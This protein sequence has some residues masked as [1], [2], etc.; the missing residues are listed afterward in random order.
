MDANI[1]NR[2]TRHTDATRAAYGLGALPSRLARRPATASAGAMLGPLVNPTGGG[3]IT[4]PPAYDLSRAITPFSVN[5]TGGGFIPRTAVA[6]AVRRVVTPFGIQTFVDYSA[7]SYAVGVRGGST[8]GGGGNIASFRT[9][10]I[11]VSQ[12]SSYDAW[13]ESRRFAEALNDS[14]QNNA[15][16]LGNLGDAGPAPSYAGLSEDNPFRFPYRISPP[17]LTSA[18]RWFYGRD[19]WNVG[20]PASWY[21]PVEYLRFA[22]VANDW[23]AVEKWIRWRRAAQGGDVGWNNI[24][25]PMPA[26]AVQAPTMLRPAVGTRDRGMVSLAGLAGLGFALPAGLSPQIQQMIAQNIANAAPVDPLANHPGLQDSGPLPPPA[27]GLDNHGV[28]YDHL[29]SRMRYVI[30]N[31]KPFYMPWSLNNYMTFAARFQRAQGGKWAGARGSLLA[32]T[33]NRPTDGCLND[34]EAQFR[35]EFKDALSSFDGSRPWLVNFEGAGCD[36]GQ[37]FFKSTLGKIV[38]GVAAIAATWGAVS[39]ISGAASAAGGASAGAVG[40]GGAGAAGATGAAVGTASGVAAGSTAAGV[41][42]AGAAAAAT[43]PEIIVVASSLAPA[44]SPGLVAAGVAASG[45]AALGITSGGSAAASAPNIPPMSEPLTAP[46]ETLE[47][48]TVTATPLPT[49]PPAAVVGGAAAVTAAVG[50]TAGG[51]GAAADIPTLDVTTGPE[52]LEPVTVTASPLPPPSPVVPA[53]I[54]AGAV[55]AGVI[56][57]GG[58]AAAPTLPEITVTEPVLDTQLP[59]LPSEPG[60]GAGAGGGAGAGSGGGLLDTI[61]DAIS[62]AGQIIGGGGVPVLP[63]LPSLDFPTLPG[64]GAGAGGGAGG[65]AA[66]GGAKSLLPFALAGLAL[67]LLANDKNRKRT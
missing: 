58:G 63:S 66:A 59:E 15:A 29:W 3:L 38:L 14:T 7:P 9:S 28:G 54:G 37:A 49:V 13:E 62:N 52:T 11:L 47:S 27:E 67:L 5:P 12:Q 24:L 20:A 41:A 39:L 53:V 46:V 21:D 57:A 45:A 42:T 2:C 40:A 43:L 36:A 26:A 1:L 18:Y 34:R 10:P 56:A 51:A 55:G 17:T 31:G 19:I 6:Q 22:M 60:A 30:Q 61:N 25:P 64:G 65:G 8:R 16:T 33:P 50:A 35:A 23:D 44:I 32:R 4:N 48:I